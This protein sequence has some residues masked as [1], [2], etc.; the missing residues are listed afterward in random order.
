MKIGK[1]GLEISSGKSYMENTV[2]RKL[3]NVYIVLTCLI[4][5]K[6]ALPLNKHA[7]Q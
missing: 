2:H 4:P 1:S 3:I 7:D 6:G 5:L